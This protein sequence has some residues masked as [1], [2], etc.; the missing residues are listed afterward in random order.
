MEVFSLYFCMSTE[1]KDEKEVEAT[2]V[3]IP[4]KST[5]VSSQ[6][7]S[8][9]HLNIKLINGYLEFIFQ[10]VIKRGRERES[11]TFN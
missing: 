7:I 8:S 11:L 1:G 4:I 2:M 10:F 3:F 9:K 6:I 5:S